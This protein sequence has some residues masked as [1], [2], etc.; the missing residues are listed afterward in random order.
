[1]IP[2]TK[3]NN[4]FEIKYQQAKRM[5]VMI[6]VSRNNKIIRF[7]GTETLELSGILCIKF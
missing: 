6:K 5:Q 2:Q 1:M 7:L 3:T 4:K